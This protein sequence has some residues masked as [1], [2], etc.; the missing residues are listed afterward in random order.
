MHAAQ[1]LNCLLFVARLS[2]I[3]TA[4]RQS[5]MNYYDEPTTEVTILTAEDIFRILISIKSKK[6]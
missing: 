4:D 3:I 2:Q 5:A 6:K 1:Q